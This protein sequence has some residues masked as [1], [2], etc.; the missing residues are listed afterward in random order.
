MIDGRT[1]PVTSR[2]D[3][4]VVVLF[5]WRHPIVNNNNK[6]SLRHPLTSSAI[7]A[8]S[9]SSFSSL[10]HTT[11]PTGHESVSS[12]C[13]FADATL[14]LAE[15]QDIAE[16]PEPRK[17]LLDREAVSTQLNIELPA[18]AAATNATN[19]FNAVTLS[20]PDNE[21]GDGDVEERGA[22]TSTATT[23]TTTTT[24]VPS[25]TRTTS[26]NRITSADVTAINTNSSAPT[27]H[28][29]TSAM[30][31]TPR[32][33]NRPRDMTW[34]LAF[35]LFVPISLTWPI[36]QNRGNHTNGMPS[37][38]T[39]SATSTSTHWMA[40]SQPPRW[41]TFQSFLLAYAATVVL[42]RLLYR[43]HGGG[44]GENARHAASQVILN[45]APISVAVYAA[46]IVALYWF[47]PSAAFPF[48]LIPLWYLIRDLYLFRRW[49]STATTPDSRQA[50]FQALTCMALDVLSRSLRRSSFY[51]MVSIL[52]V[53]QVGVIVWW[54]WALLAALQQRGDSALA[55]P[56]LVAVLVGG[57]WATGV[58]A[59]LLSLIASGGITSWFATQSKMILEL[60]RKQQLERL[61]SNNDNNNDDEEQAN[62]GFNNNNNFGSSNIQEAYRTVD[63][64]VY[65]SVL[66]MDDGLDDDFDDDEDEN[67]DLPLT[68][69]QRRGSL[70]MDS[71]GGNRQR[72]RGRN[73][74]ASSTSTATG[75]T[76][77]TQSSA[78]DYL[79]A[80]LTVSFGSVAHCGLLGGVAQFV[81]S[82]LR[83]IEAASAA[84]SAY[85]ARANG[86]G[87]FRGMRIGADGNSSSL[88]STN[89]LV[90]LW[91][92]ANV[93]A[94]NFVRGHSDLA[95]SHVAAYYK[96]YHRASL[97]VSALVDQ[98]GLCRCVLE[99]VFDAFFFSISLSSSLHCFLKRS[100][101]NHER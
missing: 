39:S 46:M 2:F 60:E 62:H 84:R 72:T 96:S 8:S 35:V 85:H 43:S 44:D 18:L 93:M 90:K 68:P 99:G 77:S 9:S 47:T 48:G 40:W 73:N 76:S 4:Q 22:N 86:S 3:I 29:P 26:F 59:R 64:S 28:N 101:A 67:D 70:G 13:F 63:A 11:T 98:S 6:N 7:M 1:V 79:I 15:A 74:V 55:W 94:R 41:A 53:V 100:G 31:T 49:Q 16:T 80:G 95:M 65:Q 50:F 32:S 57:K 61:E 21:N 78:R 25:T 19:R 97:D 58:V 52:L 14:D 42:A 56:T 88:G 92:Q 82:A 71:S 83:K 30:Y 5:W 12:G 87:G 75:G 81:W 10:D 34:A 37:D 33:A 20:K 66:D 51:R 91:N 38:S 36:S 89:I 17:V 23:T 27:C 69:A 24:N 45:F 54:Q